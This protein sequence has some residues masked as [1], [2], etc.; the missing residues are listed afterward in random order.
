MLNLDYHF[1]SQVIFEQN[2]WL[3]CAPLLKQNLIS[4]IWKSRKPSTIEKYCITL[5]KFFK[6]CNVKGFPVKIPFPS[7]LIAQY[8]EEIKS[9]TLA[10]SAVSNA[11]LSIKWL[12]GFMPGLNASND[13]TNDSFLSKIVESSNRN[14]IKLKQRKRPLPPDVIINI[15]KSPPKDPTLL[16]L[17]DC[18]IPVLAYALL[19]R[20]D[21]TSHI[22]CSHILVETDGLKIHIPSSKNDTYRDENLCISQKIIMSFMTY[23]FN[24]FQK[25][26]CLSE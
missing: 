8:L 3:D 15:L 7:L 19:L 24:I 23:F 17:R 11:L 22:N 1:L 25:L 12:H 4:T 2:F 9:V 14:C 20:H 5:R 13:P 26:T 10:K 21:E 18:L 6:F 16:Q